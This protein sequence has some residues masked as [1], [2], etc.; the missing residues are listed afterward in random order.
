MCLY[1]ALDAIN[2]TFFL[3]YKKQRDNDYFPKNMNANQYTIVH[4]FRSHTFYFE[5]TSA[6]IPSTISKQVI[7]LI[8][9]QTNKQTNKQT[10]QNIKSLYKKH[11]WQVRFT[12][13]L[14]FEP[15]CMSFNI[16]LPCFSPMLSCVVGRDFSIPLKAPSKSAKD[17]DINFGS[18]FFPFIN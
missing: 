7:N 11:K 5:E 12:I 4:A 14:C 6:T 2:L 13:L 16:S 9:K 8:S 18:N 15:F 17:F 1:I 3:K 10:K